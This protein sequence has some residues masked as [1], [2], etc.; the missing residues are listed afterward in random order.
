MPESTPKRDIAEYHVIKAK[1]QR[2]EIDVMILAFA[3]RLRLIDIKRL[4]QT[5]TPEEEA[6]LRAVA[7]T[8][9]RDKLS[10][11]QRKT[12][13]RA[14]AVAFNKAGEMVYDSSTYTELFR[15]RDEAMTALES[16]TS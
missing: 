6:Q 2:D 15:L 5:A 8:E 4:Q 16:L 14:R 1:T 12:Q 3:K 9:F 10:K 7:H 11:L 13:L